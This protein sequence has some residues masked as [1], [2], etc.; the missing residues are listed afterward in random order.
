MHI[1]LSP[2]LYSEGPAVLSTLL[3]PAQATSG[4]RCSTGTS[5][6][7]TRAA[8]RRWWRRCCWT[9]CC[10]R[11]SSPASSSP[12][13]TCCRCGTALAVSVLRWH[14]LASHPGLSFV[15]RSVDV[16]MQCEASMCHIHANFIGISTAEK[17]C[18]ILRLCEQGHPEN[19]VPAIQSKLVPMMI[20]NYAVWPVAHLINFKFVPP[21]QRILYINCCQAR[22][23]LPALYCPFSCQHWVCSG[24]SAGQ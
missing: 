15:C 8:T 21:Q 24:Q 18:L 22:R 12:S 23:R 14:V 16:G 4:T 7:R 6:L 5:S 17:H 13:S 10:G 2:T 1:C 20:A 3:V 19:I 11:R 9:S